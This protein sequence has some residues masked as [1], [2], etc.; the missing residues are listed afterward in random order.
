LAELRYDILSG[1]YAIIATERAKRPSDFRAAQQDESNV[2]EKDPQCPFCP[3]NESM[4][5]P[6]VYAVREDTRPDHAGW[7][8]RVVPN[9]FPA[10]VPKESVSEKDLDTAM[11]SLQNLPQANHEWMYWEMPAL[12]GHEVVIESP[13]HDG[14]LGSYEPSHLATILEALKT[15]ALSLYDRSE[16]AYVQAFRNTGALG[17]ASLAHP[18]FQIIALP[19]VPPRLVL[20]ISRF[21]AYQKATRR[22][23]LCDLLEREIE[24]DLRVIVKTDHYVAFC[25]FASR[26]SFEVCIAPRR[27]NSGFTQIGPKSLGDLGEIV[28]T[29]FLGYETMFSSLPYNLLIHDIPAGLGPKPYHWHIHVHPRLTVEAGLEIGTGVQINPTSPEEACKQFLSIL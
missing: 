26:H 14:T 3:G 22:C 21:D 8:V 11:A 17:G 28:K 18:H 1:D 23:L 16:V 29:V 5:P 25:P 19:V 24:K 7:S 9:K 13:K 2:P 27:H 6:E 15:R 4:T 12:G 10:L 20:E